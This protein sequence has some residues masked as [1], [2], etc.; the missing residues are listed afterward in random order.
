[1]TH[2]R[3]ECKVK[4]ST[5]FGEQKA[6]FRRLEMTEWLSEKTISLP[7]AGTESNAEIMAS[8]SEV[9]TGFIGLKLL[10]NPLCSVISQMPKL[11]RKA[12]FDASVTIKCHP[13]YLA[14][15]IEKSCLE[16]NLGAPYFK[17]PVCSRGSLW[18]SQG[19][20]E[21][22]TNAKCVGA[23]SEVERG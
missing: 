3:V 21:G 22:T 13:V 18:S 17:N 8:A 6:T 1:M 11:V 23:E 7:C 5:T 16:E 12:V 9:K 20:D 2:W 19:E 10:K 14:I 15:Y 4:V